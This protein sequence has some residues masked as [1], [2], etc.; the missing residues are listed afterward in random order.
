MAIVVLLRIPRGFFNSLS[1]FGF[2]NFY[3]PQLALLVFK[4]FNGNSRSIPSFILRK[5]MLF[6]KMKIKL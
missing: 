1:P 5:N 3:F 4:T 2:W 6:Y